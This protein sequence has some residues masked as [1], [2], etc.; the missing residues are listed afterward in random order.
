MS[1]DNLKQLVEKQT[2]EIA[3]LKSELLARDTRIADLTGLLDKYQSVFSRQTNQMNLISD[4]LGG[5]T[6]PS[7]KP[8][9]R[10]I[11]I[12]AEPEDA[13]KIMTHELKRY[14][15]PNED[16][17]QSAL[18]PTEFELLDTKAKE[19]KS[20]QGKQCK[21]RQ[22][23]EFEKLLSTTRCSSNTAEKNRPLSEEERCLLEKGLNFAVSKGVI[24]AEEIVP[25]VESVFQK[26]PSME[27]EKLRVLLVTVLK[28][29][30]PGVP[31][32]APAERRALNTLKNVDSIVITK[33]DKG[34]A[35][36]VMNKSDYLHKVRQHIADGPYRQS[37][38]GKITS[39][40]SSKSKVEVGKYLRSEINHLGQG[41]W[42]QLYPK[43]AIQP[44]L[45]GLPKIHKEGVF[46]SP[47]VDGIG[48]PPYQLARYLA[49]ILKPLAGKSPTHIQVAG[50]QME[51]DEV[52]ASFDVNSMYTNVPR[53]D[54]VEVA[55][56]L[57]LAD[58]MLKERTQLSVDE[59]VEG[60][61][62]C[63]NLSHFVSDSVVYTQEQGLAMGSPISPILANIVRKIIKQAIMENDFLNH[64]AQDQ[65]N[66][67]ID[68]MYLIAHRAGETLINEGDFGDLVYVLFDGVL[69][70]WKDGVKVRDVNRCTVL[71]EL[72]VLY[73][74][75]RTATVKAA[76]ACRLWAIDR[77]SFQTILRKKNIQRLQSRLAF[78]RSVPTFHDLP[79]TT[80]SQ[81][82]DQLT[83]VRY[84][85]NEYVIRQGARGDNFY[86]VCQGQV[87]VTVQEVEKSGEINT[88]TKPKFIR[89]LGRGEWFGEMALKGSYN[90]LIGDLEALQRHYADLKIRQ[91]SKL[92][93]RTRFSHVLLENLKTIGTMGVGG[94]GRVEL[95]KLND[96][97]GQ[98]FALKK[99]KKNHIVRT[100]QQEHVINEKT[101]LLEVNSEFIV[102]LWKTFRDSKYVYLLMEPCLG[103]ELWTLLRDQFFFNETTTQFYVACVVEALDYLHS[104]NI[105]FRDL[106]P[107][108]LILDNEG[109][110]KLTDFGFAKR[111]PS[112]SKTWTFCG[113][114]E[115]MAP[116][117]IL[118]KGHDS[119][120]DFWSLGI[121]IYELLTGLPPFD[122]PDAMRTYNLIL[123]GLDAV[124]FPPKVT[125]NAQNLIR[126]L[127]RDSSVERFGYGK[128]GI[129]EVEKHVW[130]EG[131]DWKGLQKRVLEPPY[132]R[133][134]DSQQDL[135]NFDKC[136][137]DKGE[138]PD[139]LSGWDANF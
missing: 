51:P 57:L 78:L 42:Y 50:L 11:G 31:N 128:G 119:A 5:G 72:A 131:F 13:S 8:R 58:T 27:A 85:P 56:R 47:I 33:A 34:K 104:L 96:S 80:L 36:V 100:K 86:I 77:K 26:L 22:I 82:A 109:Y 20:A 75:E 10:G 37:S 83:E 73:N 134:V 126:K 138:P 76:T 94:F 32:I 62:V 23:R 121:L 84:A 17:L 39:I 124:G 135:R 7:I 63:L 106:K 98:S 117:V 90:A 108:N 91:V 24:R 110:C 107:E 88:S 105:I 92:E 1:T 19:V 67:L 14:P 45:Y 53:A 66:N 15:K 114:P 87:H 71:G 103:G 41:K 65:L 59:I 137:E 21:D 9:K 139:E 93:D 70:I 99:M 52:L 118:N 28:S 97:D 44:R 113:T 16:D 116:E 46:I 79:D 29:Q 30:Q 2:A 122:S 120:V 123:K 111:V 81:M 125:G 102:K 38:N 101:I 136:P 12:S 3:A 89:T 49:G 68:C 127:C 133:Q 60:I 112:G 95:V 4:G 18:S 132:R 130:F 6:T 55:R 43:S 48:S 25:S 115:Y 54:A 129:R 61:K 40:M 35:T 69:E 64:L 74:C